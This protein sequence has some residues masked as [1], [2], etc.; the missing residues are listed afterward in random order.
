MSSTPRAYAWW[1]KTGL[2]AVWTHAFG[3]PVLPVVN[4]QIAMSSRAIGAASRSAV[5]RQTSA[6][7]DTSPPRRS[8][9][10]AARTGKA[11][12]SAASEAY[13]DP[14]V[15][16]RV[17]RHHWRGCVVEVIHVVL[18]LQERV[19]LGGHGPDLL[20]RVPGGDKLRRVGQ[21][22]EH[23]LVSLDAEFDERVAQIGRAHV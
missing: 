6:S 17:D 10:G 14:I 22:E 1:L 13:P 8:L 2:C 9:S 23:A 11:A 5:W 19:H 3:L 15:G 18:G 16:A 21:G 7:K 20:H 12:R 4:F